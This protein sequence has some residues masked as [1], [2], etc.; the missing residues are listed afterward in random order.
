M[1][2]NE[3]VTQFGADFST[4]SGFKLLGPVEL[5]V[6]SNVIVVA[7]EKAVSK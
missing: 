5:G 6:S 3:I 1:K 4:F 7:D 2:T